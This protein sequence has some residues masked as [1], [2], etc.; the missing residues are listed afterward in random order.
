MTGFQAKL[1]RVENL[2]VECEL[3]AKRVDGCNASCISVRASTIVSWQTHVRALIA[4]F[5]IAA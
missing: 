5:N 2:A 1:E 4:S 3:I